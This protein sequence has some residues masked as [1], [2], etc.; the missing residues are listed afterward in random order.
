MLKKEKNS[1]QKIVFVCTGNTCR[2]PMADW[3]FNFKLKEKNL[4]DKWTGTSAGISTIDGFPASVN[5][6]AVMEEIGI[7]ISDHKAKQIT[8][9][10]INEA[11][12]ILTMSENHKIF[13]NNFNERWKEKVF[14]LKEYTADKPTKDINIEDPFGTDLNNYRKIR[15]IIINNID[16]LLEII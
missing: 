6:I 14:T 16:K 9:Q 11:E 4:T 5:S 2:S 8:E 7:N 15:K 3:Y 13:I 12:L 1:K 10:L